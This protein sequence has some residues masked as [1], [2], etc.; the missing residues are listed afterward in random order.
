MKKLI[1]NQENL[2]NNLNILQEKAKKNNTNIIAVVKGNGMG[3]GLIE[4]SKFLVQNGINFLATSET[5]EA[6]RLRKSGINEKILL[7]TPVILEK[8]LKNLV[9]NNIILTIG[10]KEQI[11]IIEEMFENSEIDEIPV[12]IKIDTGFARYGFEYSSREEILDAISMC[13]KIKICG[14]YTHFFKPIDEKITKNQFKKFNEVIDFIKSCGYNPGI[15]HCAEST[16]FLEYEN[17]TMDAVRIGSAIQGRTMKPVDGL[18]KVGYLESNILEIKKIP[19]GHNI[20][21]GNMFKTK[22]ETKIAIIPV[23]YMDGLNMRKDRDIFSFK[24]NILSVGIE[25]KKFFKDNNIKVCINN[26]NC[27]IIGRIGMY[28]CVADITNLEDVN[29]NDKVIFNIQPLIINSEIRREYL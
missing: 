27:N 3:L 13:K 22:K 23:G 28:H 7:L 18:K 19:K 5:D 14:I 15:V 1:I 6:I 8:E 12:H 29:I 11:K 24:E 2:K 4:Y 20:S 17:M 10:S 25:V 26:K 21:Y 16:A 9:E